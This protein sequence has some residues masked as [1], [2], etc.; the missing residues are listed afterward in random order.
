MAQRTP[1]Q[2]R[3]ELEQLELRKVQLRA[4]IDAGDGTPELMAELEQV[5]SRI[6]FL[7]GIADETGALDEKGGGY[8]PK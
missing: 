7:F 5:S 4:D 2:L 3:A 6:E 1:A 8:P